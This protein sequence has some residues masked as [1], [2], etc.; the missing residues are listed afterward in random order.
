VRRAETLLEGGGQDEALHRQARAR[1]AELEQGEAAAR[2]REAERKKDRRMLERLEEC[3]FLKT[4]MRGD[5]FDTTEAVAGYEEAFR[6]Y[7]IDPDE[8]SAKEAAARVKAS[9]LRA[10]LAAAMDDWGLLCVDV[11]L[12]RLLRPKDKG[13]KVNADRAGWLFEAARTAD[14]TD[15]WRNG[16]RAALTRPN[17]FTI[18]ADLTKLARSADVVKVPPPSLALLG[19]C[20]GNLGSPAQA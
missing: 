15:P 10:E 9:A 3:R 8:L 14:D 7:G 4:M 11:K 16:L 18:Q 5:G 17:L 12:K 19:E 6:E 20:L 13:V 1:R 2:Q